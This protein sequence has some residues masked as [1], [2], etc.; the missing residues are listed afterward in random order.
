MF[1]NFADAGSNVFQVES[2]VNFLQNLDFKIAYKFIDLYY[3]KNGNRLDQPFNSKNRVL[4]GITYTYPQNL[5]VFNANVQWFGVQNI[6][7][8]E[9]Y[10]VQ[11]QRALTSDP[12]TLV[13]VQVTKNFRTFELYAGVENLMNFTQENPI[14]SADNPFN[15][16]FDTSYIWGPTRGRDF[17]FGFR[18]FIK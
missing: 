3:F 2:S 15:K 18:F 13:N 14:I 7:S 17:Y 4:F 5:W 16:N 9:K 8:T 12:Y 1:T 10:P 6:P 11:Y